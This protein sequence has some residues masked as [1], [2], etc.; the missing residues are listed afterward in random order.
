MGE[1]L[2]AVLRVLLTAAGQVLSAIDLHELWRGR[3]RR[4]RLAALARGERVAIPCVLSDPALTGGQRRQGRL[5]LGTQPLT[6]QADGRSEPAPF[7]PGPLTME[8]VD[9]KAITFRSGD[10]RTELRLHPDE[11]PHVLSALGQPQPP[12]P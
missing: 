1:L 2:G 10:G 7:A 5:W 12:A 11:A 8:A 3:R 6:W 4:G 9:A